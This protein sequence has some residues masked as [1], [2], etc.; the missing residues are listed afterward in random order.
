M[1]GEQ[2]QFFVNFGV[3]VAVPKRTLD[4]LWIGCWRSECRGNSDNGGD[5]ARGVSRLSI[6]RRAAEG[7]V[8]YETFLELGPSL[9]GLQGVI[10]YGTD[11]TVTLEGE[12]GINPEDLTLVGSYVGTLTVD[13]IADILLGLCGFELNTQLL[14]HIEFQEVMFSM[15]SLG[16]TVDARDL[17]C[18]LVSVL[19]L[20]EGCVFSSLVFLTPD[21]FHG[22]GTLENLE[23]GPLSL[24]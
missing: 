19:L 1:S 12:F 11:F 8:I 7:R 24:C 14:P 3:T 16:G 20:F 10:S 21:G 5:V 22:A 17:S 18:R 4:S 13:Q 23:I 9:L 15:S 6:G 2:C